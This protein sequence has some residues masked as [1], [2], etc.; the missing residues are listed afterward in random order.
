MI[1]TRL[2]PA[3][4]FLTLIT[5]T[6]SQQ[7]EGDFVIELTPA[8]DGK[9]VKPFNISIPI[10]SSYTHS[11]PVSSIN[12]RK[13][14]T[15]GMQLYAWYNGGWIIKKSRVLRICA[16]IQKLLIKRYPSTRRRNY[17]W[18]WPKLG[19]KKVLPWKIK[20]SLLKDKSTFPTTL[21][22]LWW[23]LSLK[24]PR[25]SFL[26]PIMSLLKVSAKIKEKLRLK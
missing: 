16:F 3:L 17:R 2:V 9:K 8:M 25:F 1:L 18:N 23:L 14:I 12:F 19:S 15:L 6:T 22:V 7:R 5:I 11:L 26:N 13:N 10:N 4:L 24:I 20:C 21:K